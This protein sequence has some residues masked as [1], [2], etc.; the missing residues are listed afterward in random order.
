[1]GTGK[2]L[3]VG[4][5]G[6]SGAMAAVALLRALLRQE[7]VGR[8]HLVVS[9]PAFT[10][11]GQELEAPGLDAAGFVRRFLD[12]DRR[13]LPYRNDQLAAPIASGSHR[14]HGMVIIPCSV[15]TLA[16]IATGIADRL[17]TRAADVVLK[18]RRPLLLAI[19]EAPLGTVHLENMLRVSRNGAVVF[20][21]APAFYARPASLEEMLDNFVLRLLDHLGLEPDR[22]YRWGGPAAGS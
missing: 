3:I 4:V 14:T 8:I 5:T 20:P 7:A 17:M 6:A 1:M 12:G 2:E 21:I 10:V 16:A 19:R 18:E 9:E 22:G 15:N 11:I 13:I